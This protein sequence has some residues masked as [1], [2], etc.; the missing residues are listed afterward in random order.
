M[1]VNGTYPARSCSPPVW[2]SQRKRAENPV[3]DIK[4]NRSPY[5][6]LFRYQLGIVALAGLV[7]AVVA[8]VTMNLGVGIL[9]LVLLVIGGAGLRA[10]APSA[11]PSTRQRWW[12]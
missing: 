2:S 8:I 4:A 7:F 6:G 11:S 12:N 9:A 10:Y 5:R 1:P 3:V